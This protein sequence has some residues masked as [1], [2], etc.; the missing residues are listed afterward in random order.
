MIR[1]YTFFIALG[2]IFLALSGVAYLIHYAIFHDVRHIFIY[3]VGDLAFLPLEVFIV[4]VVIERILAR[5]DKQAMLQKLN[6]VVGAFF[7]EIGDYLL[8]DLL[9]Y[10]HNRFEISQHMNVRESWT[11]N[12][13]KK[14]AEYARHLRVEVDCHNI[15][16]ERL[17][18][19]LVQKRVFVLRL[20][21]NPSL[22]EHDRFTDLLW[23]ATHLDEELEA[24]LSLRDLPERDLEHIAGDIQRLYQHL[25]TEWLDYVEHLKV[26]Y[27]FLFSL[28]LRTHPF[29]E[30]QSPVFT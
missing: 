25:A 27:P 3:M 2:A 18:A 24:R 4:V 13:F 12:D 29:Q 26:N 15:D 14:A 22:L 1:R 17:R 11:K 23:A 16:L 30:H 28:V 5:R 6:M 9:M 21:E 19:F 7:S 10:F 8:R 20:L